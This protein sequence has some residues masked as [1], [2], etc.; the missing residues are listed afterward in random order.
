MAAQPKVV[1]VIDDDASMLK[2]ITRLL[3]LHGFAT[4]SYIS[5]ESYLKD[6]TQASSSVTC[7][8]LDIHLGGISG[9]EL[10]RHLLLHGSTV[11]IVYM[12]AIDDDATRNEALDIGCI[13]FLRKP[14]AAK[15][16]LGAIADADNALA[17]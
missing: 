13:A 4:Q 9:I 2:S 5:A 3:T 11:P 12:T 6:K 1:V 16:L 15:E 17:P 8:L 10:H 14:F 7:L